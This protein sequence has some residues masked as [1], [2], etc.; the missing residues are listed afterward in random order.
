MAYLTKRFTRR[1]C[2][3][4]LT[5]IA[6]SA[7]GAGLASRL[8]LAA[9]APHVI[10]LGMSADTLAGANV[11][12]ARAA[13]QVWTKEILRLLPVGGAEVD[14]RIFIPSDV[15]LR[16]IRQGTIGCF[17]VNAME[18]SKLQDLADPNYFLVQDYM[19][20]GI[21]YVLLVHNTSSFKKTAD[22]RG[23]ELLMHQHRDTV[24][25]AA[26]LSVLLATNNLGQ[27]EQFFAGVNQVES[28]NQ[29]LLP[30]FFR[31]ADAACLARRSWETAVELNPQ[32]GRDLRP[33]AASPKVIPVVLAFRRDLNAENQKTVL[34][35]F[36]KLSSVAG[37]QQVISL[38]QAHGLITRPVAAMKSTLEMIHRYERMSVAQ[39]G[40]QRKSS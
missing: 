5:A 20:D 22:L 3:G 14:P 28:L 26:W 25:A 18:Y 40:A 35:V 7:A 11:N 29:V 16:E 4:R 19:A 6:A 32:L 10:R 2:L 30:V 36:L 1:Q 39:A 21:D 23:T 38:Y 12:D 37:G 31:R 17:V 24:L 9:D 27:P 13:Y 15:L 8:A 33:L 34:D